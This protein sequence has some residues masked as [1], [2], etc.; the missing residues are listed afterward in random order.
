MLPVTW[1]LYGANGYTGEL[2]AEE[3]ARRGMKPVLAGRTEARVRPIAERLRLEH[4]TFALDDTMTVASN[5]DG[6]D[7]VLLAAGP[8]SHTSRPVVDACLTRG[9]HYLDITGEIGVFEAVFARDRKARDLGCVLMPGVGFD[10]VPSDCLAVS[11]KDALPDADTLE[12]AFHS[13]GGPSAGTTKTVIENLPRG[14]AARVGGRLVPV[15]TAWR[16]RDVPFRDRSRFAVSIPWGDVS[17]AYRSTGIPNITVYMA[18]RPRQATVMRLTRPIA[19]LLGLAP[20]QALLKGA[21][22]RYVRGPGPEERA[23]RRAQLWGRASGGGRAVEGTLV[24]P[25][26]YALTVLTA[27]EITDRVLAGGVAPGAWTP[28][29]AFGGGFITEIAG[30]DLRIE[31]PS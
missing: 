14:A 11:L 5:L 26:G 23:T 29:Q 18:T 7:L 22:E 3:A 24:T 31:S 21:A 6:I 13:G 16:T 10:V 4:R 1:M 25:E 12:L 19:P 9:A 28:G 2:I 30:C 20:I 15:P 8:F 27:V 17:T